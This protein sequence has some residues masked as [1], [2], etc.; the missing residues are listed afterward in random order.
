M[1]KRA[2]AGDRTVAFPI[3]IQELASCNTHV[4]LT[5]LNIDLACLYNIYSVVNLVGLRNK[6]DY[7]LHQIPGFTQRR[8]KHKNAYEFLWLDESSKLFTDHFFGVTL[9]L[10]LPC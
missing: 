1:A 7:T 8:G 4:C 3:N 5:Q 10:P 6:N 2:F 9:L